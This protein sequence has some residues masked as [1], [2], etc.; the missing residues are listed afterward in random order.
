MSTALS[1]ALAGLSA[2]AQAINIVSANM[3][4]INTT[5]YKNQTVSFEDLMSQSLNGGNSAAQAGGNTV[6]I[7]SRHFTQGSVQTT[8]QAY[9]AAVQG[10]G[11]FVLQSPA[12]QQ[13]YS[14]AGTFSVDSSGNLIAPGGQNVQGWNASAGVL[15]TSAALSNITLP[16][17]GI[18]APKATSTFSVS[19][20]LNASA[21]VGSSD[22]TFSTP[23]Q[24]VDAQGGQH[25]LTI[26]YT[27]TSPD[28]WGY[29]VT[30]PSSDLTSGTGSTTTLSSG[31]LTF[32][33]SGQL[34]TP[35]AS[36]KPI[37]IQISGLA[38]GAADT[39]V[40]WNLYD[41]KGNALL[42]SFNQPS[43]NLSSQQNGTLAS[44]VTD[45]SIGTNGAVHANYSDGTSVTVAQLALASVLNPGTMQDLGNNIYGATAAT[46]TP[47][48]GMPGTGARGQIV[49][50]ALESSTVDIATEMTHLLTYERGYQADSKVITTEDEILQATIALKP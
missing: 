11:F 36:A 28:N 35:A 13:V 8:G 15:D 19:A 33:S 9:D 49:G 7:S 10:N 1:N 22:G 37:A 3:S 16:V 14:R 27:E 31:T 18:Q 5:G 40:N 41:A 50:G 34:T 46:A 43:S 2:N 38:N 39:T 30:I 23:I 17:N 47:T 42:T 29:Q 6:A 44:Q 45:I 20:N 24:I 32:N 21:A 4:N 48:V 25:V 26:T 12:G